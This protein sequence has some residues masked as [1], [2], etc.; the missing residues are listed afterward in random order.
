MKN[1][2]NADLPVTPVVNSNGK[3]QPFTDDNGFSLIATGM[4]K[5]EAFALAAMQGIC[6]SGPSISN[7]DIAIQS[8]YLADA[9]LAELEK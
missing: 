9:L 5:R 6:S 3:I 4:T 8:I 7:A 1:I 2:K